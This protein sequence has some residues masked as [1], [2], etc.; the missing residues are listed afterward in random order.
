MASD[1]LWP[2]ILALTTCGLMIGV[3]FHWSSVPIGAVFVF[4]ALCGWFWPT[5]DMEPIRHEEHPEAES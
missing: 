2:L 3:I 5:K 1:S 4:F